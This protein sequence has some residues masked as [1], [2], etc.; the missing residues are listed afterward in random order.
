MKIHIRNNCSLE[1]V[2]PRCHQRN[3]AEV[4]IQNFKTHFLSV[5]AGVADGFPPSLWDRLL[6]Q[7]KITLNLLCQSKD[8]LTVLA[9]A[10]LNGPFNYNK[11]PLAPMGYNVQVHKNQTHVAHGHTT[12][13]TDGTCLPPQTITKRIR[14]TSNPLQTQEHHQPIADTHLQ[15]HESHC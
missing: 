5:L 2:P 8:T 12:Q 6:P 15:N 13:S 4:A 14:A 9:Y 10:H 7:T 1:L 3:A 11:M